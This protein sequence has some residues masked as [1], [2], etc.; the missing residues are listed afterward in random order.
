MDRLYI[1]LYALIIAIIIVILDYAIFSLEET[2]ELYCGYE[3]Y[4][5]FAITNAY[6]ES[7]TKSLIT[8]EMGN[9]TQLVIL[10]LQIERMWPF[11]QCKVRELVLEQT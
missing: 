4:Q 8:M 6:K 9:E 5:C 7:C 2:R 1:V 3:D 11:R 10:Q